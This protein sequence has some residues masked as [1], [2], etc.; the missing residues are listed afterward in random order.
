M[1]YG[2][3]SRG[4]I[5]YCIYNFFS[6]ILWK[7]GEN[8]EIKIDQRWLRMDMLRGG[9]TLD[10]LAINQAQR[11]RECVTSAYGYTP[12]LDIVVRTVFPTIVRGT[13]S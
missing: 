8:S 6:A 10:Q 11:R 5:Q 12:I 4:V 7:R 1:T 2:L 13:H 9:P 3:A